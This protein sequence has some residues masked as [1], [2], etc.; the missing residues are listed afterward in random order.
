MDA[1]ETQQQGYTTY[2]KF[3]PAKILYLAHLAAGREPDEIVKLLP[4]G[5]KKAKARKGVVAE[6][7]FGIEMNTVAQWRCRDKG[8]ADA[9]RRTLEDPN[10]FADN[11]GLPVTFHATNAR[12][13]EYVMG[14]A[15]EYKGMNGKSRELL[16]GQ[17][18][19]T[20]AQDTADDRL[21]ALLANVKL[22]ALVNAPQMTYTPVPSLQAPDMAQTIDAGDIEDGVVVEMLEAVSR[23]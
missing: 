8:W 21:K 23:G 15:G 9:E 17:M 12:D 4:N 2:T 18:G 22:V 3:G 20:V 16:L 19:R 10:W 7:G 13:L 5:K 1:D 11:I 14:Y 6:T